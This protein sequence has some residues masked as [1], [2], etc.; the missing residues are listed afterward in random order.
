MHIGV[1]STFCDPRCPSPS[2]TSCTFQ[3][4]QAVDSDE[5][6]GSLDAD[7]QDSGGEAF[8]VRLGLSDSAQAQ[9]DS[10]AISIWLTYC[11]FHC[12]HQYAR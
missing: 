10:E 1:R 5:D 12:V 11:G 8:A 2:D 7:W 3:S 4:A 9:K 6:E